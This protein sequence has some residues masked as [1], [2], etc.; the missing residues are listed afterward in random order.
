MSWLNGISQAEKDEMYLDACE[1]FNCN[2]ITER[3]FRDT[4]GRLGYNATDIE[5]CVRQHSPDGDNDD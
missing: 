4:L 1:A 3:E 2:I 5:D